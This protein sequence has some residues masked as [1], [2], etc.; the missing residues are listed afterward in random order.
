MKKI[1]CILSLLTIA[2]FAFTG[3]SSD[4]LSRFDGSNAQNDQNQSVQPASANNAEGQ[5]EPENKEESG[6][7]TENQN[8]ARQKDEP[9]STGEE[10]KN[11]TDWNSTTAEDGNG[12]KVEVK[13]DSGR[14]Q[15]QADNNFIEIKISGVPD[16]KATKV[17]MLSEKV[18]EKFSELKLKTGDEVKFQY[19]ENEH[20][21][22]V[23]VDITKI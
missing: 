13:T 1:I 7:V 14:Y 8:T 16:E 3:C 20:A 11:E 18:K 2:I 6:Q 4:L 12:N 17:F 19:Y 9:I 10:D 21:Q 5:G 23:I 15:G 22:P